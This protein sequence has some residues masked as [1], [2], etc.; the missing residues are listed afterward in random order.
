MAFQSARQRR[1]IRLPD[2]DYRCS[3]AYFVTICTQERAIVFDDPAIKRGVE[4]ALLSVG[5][6]CRPA[7]IDEFVVM[8][9]H[10]HAIIW[11]SHERIQAR[12]VGAQHT[13]KAGPHLAKHD[14]PVAKPRQVDACAAPL[15]DD[16]PRA[17]PL[18]AP[19]VAAGS[20]GAIVRAFKST[21]AKRVN[22]M[23]NT[24]GA[25]VWQRNYYEHVIRGDDDLARTR[26]YI[27][28]NPAKWADDPDNPA[29]VSTFGDPT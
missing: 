20:L 12:G 11:I 5:R 13:P 27:R 16:S 19:R 10:V 8:P 21:S 6:Y 9:N 2:Y 15:R 18:S 29:N 23:R 3:G 17:A 28:D 22:A 14:H 25:P 1:S 4:L 7:S 24:P 26:Q